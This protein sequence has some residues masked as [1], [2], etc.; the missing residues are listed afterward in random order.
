MPE[1]VIKTGLK[2]YGTVHDTLVVS[3]LALVLT[4]D[5]TPERALQSF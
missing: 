3:L 1:P 4:A 2:T 5:W